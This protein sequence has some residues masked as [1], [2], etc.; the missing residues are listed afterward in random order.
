MPASRYAIYV[1]LLFQGTHDYLL[2]K[3]KPNMSQSSHGTALIGAT[4]MTTNGEFT[5]IIIIIIIIIYDST[6]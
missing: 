1:K 4:K 2:S 6:S 5:I 3:F